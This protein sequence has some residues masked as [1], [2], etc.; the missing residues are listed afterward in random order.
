MKKSKIIKINKNKKKFLNNEKNI[1]ISSFLNYLS[2]LENI[3]I[4]LIIINIKSKYNNSHT[5]YL[6]VYEDIKLKLQKRG[7]NVKGFKYIFQSIF[8]SPN[9][10][11][12]F[13][14]NFPFLN[15]KNKNNAN[16]IK[17]IK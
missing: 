9:N 13:N 5:N 15:N 14:K 6:K 17:E 1:T 4:H 16:K 2:S 12:N 10:K 3:P 7:Y 11:N 8:H